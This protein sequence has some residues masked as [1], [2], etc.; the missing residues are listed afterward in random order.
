MSQWYCERCS[1][2]FNEP[3]HGAPEAEAYA[4][5]MCPVCGGFLAKWKTSPLAHLAAAEKRLAENRIGHSPRPAT[6]KRGG[7]L[8]TLFRRRTSQVGTPPV[9]DASAVDSGKDGPFFPEIMAPFSGL[10][11]GC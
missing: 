10:L 5:R 9:S 3:M 1:K 7:W 8:Q 11:S 2:Y 6:A 4:K